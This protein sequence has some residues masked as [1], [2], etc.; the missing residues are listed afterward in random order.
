MSIERVQHATPERAVDQEVITHWARRF[1]ASPLLPRNLVVFARDASGKATKTPD[2]DATALAVEL[3]AL[4]GAALGIEP[5]IA[6][7]AFD[8]IDGS[9]VP[10]AKTMLAAV[11]KAGYRIWWPEYSSERVTVAARMPGASA[12][13]V[14]KVTF[15]MD[16]ARRAGLLDE[17]YEKWE[18]AESGK[19]YL[20][21]WVVGSTEETPAW[22]KKLQ[23][24]GEKPR[25]RENWWK[26]PI[27]MLVARASVRLGRLLATFEMSGGIRKAV[28]VLEQAEQAEDSGA[29]DSRYDEHPVVAD[30]HGEIMDPFG[31]ESGVDDAVLVPDEAPEANDSPSEDDAD[32]DEPDEPDEAERLAIAVEL[33]ESLSAQHLG[34]A[35]RNAFWLYA[36]GH[37][38]R[39]PRDGTLKELRD[40]QRVLQD[41][42]TGEADF[43]NRPDGLVVERRPA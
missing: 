38:L 37:A 42:E 34:T 8:V 32:P 43:V 18:R 2:I 5:A 29:F 36:I 16:D 28:E 26:W 21:R 15:T 10:T 14:T 7:Q 39:S 30:G 33:A 9:V 4:K 12:D 6:I 25:R 31:H 1:A 40:A 3:V 13:E 20:S 41:I 35:E 23:A 17:W 27:D 19:S 22:V 24:A 11:E